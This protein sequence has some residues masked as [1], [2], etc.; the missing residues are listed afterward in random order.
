MLEPAFIETIWTI[1][2][3]GLLFAAAALSLVALPWTER[4]IRDVHETA[5]ALFV[6]RDLQ[7]AALRARRVAR[8]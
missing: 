2:V 4:E 1:C 7:P 6:P 5:L 3:V 8:R